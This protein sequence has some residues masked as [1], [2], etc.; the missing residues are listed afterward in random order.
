M[1]AVIKMTKEIINLIDICKKFLQNQIIA[2]E[3]INL[4]EDAFYNTPD[5][6]F[7]EEELDI[8]SGIFDAN[9]MFEPHAL[10]RAESALYID[11]IEL[12]R[13][14]QINIAKLT[15]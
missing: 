6:K 13:R 5:D 7:S 3:Y 11:E 4:F 12:R 1:E 8:L 10:L 9:D 15:A 2:T 14:V